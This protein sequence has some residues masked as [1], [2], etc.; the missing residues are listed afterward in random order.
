MLR[1]LMLRMMRM[2]RLRKV[3]VVSVSH[4]FLFPLVGWD[5]IKRPG[6]RDSSVGVSSL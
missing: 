3:R 4:C 5:T 1:M 2:L 6:S